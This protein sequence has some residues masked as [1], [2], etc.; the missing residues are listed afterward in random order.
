MDSVPER[1]SPDAIGPEFDKWMLSDAL[2]SLSADH[3]VAV[4]RAH[5]LG[6]TVGDIA[7]HEEIS[8]GTV[9]SRLHYASRSL[10]SA[11]QERGVIR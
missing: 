1:S 4:V 7:A 2:L 10:R 6:Q 3:R 5:Y 9:K 8:E 11:L